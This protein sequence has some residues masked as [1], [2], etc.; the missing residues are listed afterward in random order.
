MPGGKGGGGKG[1]GGCKGHS[2]GK[3]HSSF[4]SF[5]REVQSCAAKS[6]RG[7]VEKGSPAAI[8][9][10]FADRGLNPGAAPQGHK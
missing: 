9:Q 5:A 3:G 1:G 10:S 7:G 4:T 8:I 2:G 6:H